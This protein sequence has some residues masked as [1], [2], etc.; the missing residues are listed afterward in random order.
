MVRD[1]SF[2]KATR[3]YAA[4]KQVSGKFPQASSNKIGALPDI[5]CFFLVMLDKR[6]D[7]EKQLRCVWMDAARPQLDSLQ[8]GWFRGPTPTWNGLICIEH[9]LNMNSLKHSSPRQV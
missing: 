8:I 2:Y 4:I 6:N 7:A 5:A 3:D 9:G 1:Q